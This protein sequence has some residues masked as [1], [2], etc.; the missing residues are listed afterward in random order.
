MTYQEVLIVR[1]ER[2]R[3][4]NRLQAR[5]NAV[6]G[7][8][9]AHRDQ[10]TFDDIQHIYTKEVIKQMNLKELANMKT[11]GNITDL[12]SLPTDVEVFEEKG[13]TKEGRAYI[14]N[15]IELNGKKYRIPASVLTAIGKLGNI[16]NIKVESTG[17]GMDTR[18]QVIAL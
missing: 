1:K 7:S 16:K 6:R 10:K 17:S 4:E 2:I 11:M 18:Y 9:I 3:W 13:T 14:F 8:G 5:I 12:E 15:Y